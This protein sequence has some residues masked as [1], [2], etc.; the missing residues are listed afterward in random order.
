LNE[1]LES[2]V[3]LGDTYSLFVFAM[4]AEQTKEKYITRLDRFFRFVD[5]QGNSTEKRCKAFC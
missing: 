4:N 1:S 3:E 5:I 2:K